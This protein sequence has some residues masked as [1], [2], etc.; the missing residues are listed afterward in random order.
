V[1]GEE[2]QGGKRETWTPDGARASSEGQAPAAASR[3]KRPAKRKSAKPRRQERQNGDLNERQRR[4][5]E[6]YMANPNGREAARS[7]GYKGS[8]EYL[9]VCASRLI[10]TDKVRAAIAARAKAD[11]RVATR[12][13][14]QRFWTQV[15]MGQPHTELVRDRKGRTREVQ[16]SPSMRERLRAAQLLGMSQGD[17]VMKHEHSLVGSKL[18]EAL[19]K[20]RQNAAKARGLG[21]P[22]GEPST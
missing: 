12:E 20:A 13:D 19:E 10:R 9:D 18:R 1:S 17:F 14:R 2:E 22:T 7:A 3:S 21:E 15:M 6:S 5:V 4:F 16:A 8:D 11:P